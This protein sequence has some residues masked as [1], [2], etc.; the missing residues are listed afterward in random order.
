ML[1]YLKGVLAEEILVLSCFPALVPLVGKER[2]H[3]LE[4]SGDFYILIFIILNIR[5]LG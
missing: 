2:F 5:Q 1:L 4:K 3:A